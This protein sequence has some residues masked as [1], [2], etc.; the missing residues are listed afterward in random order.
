MDFF[1]KK[2]RNVEGKKRSRKINF[3]EIVLAVLMLNCFERLE[4]LVKKVINELCRFLYISSFKSCMLC[5][6]VSN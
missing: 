6:A 4:I 5:F 1:L 2:K 3:T